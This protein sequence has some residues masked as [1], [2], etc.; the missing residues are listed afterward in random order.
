MIAVDPRNTSRSCSACRHR[1]KVNR[2]THEKFHCVACGHTAHTDTVAATNVLRAGLVRRNANPA[3]S[4]PPATCGW[5]SS[6]T[7][8]GG[9]RNESAQH[10]LGAT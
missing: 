5:P 6:G 9:P 3:P 4:P 8:H 1:A 7:D 2:P 10:L